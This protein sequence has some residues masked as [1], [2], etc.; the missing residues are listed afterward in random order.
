MAGQLA[1][2]TVLIDNERVRVNELRF[3]PGGS[4]G[5]HRH[6]FD[7]VVVPITKGKFR[8]K[9]ANGTTETDLT[10]GIPYFRP[11]GVEHDVTNSTSDESVFIE[12]E[13]K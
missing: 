9:D 4:T 6:G 12:I 2:S 3:P 5:H 13:I 11:E 8:I 10:P 7:Y 1:Q